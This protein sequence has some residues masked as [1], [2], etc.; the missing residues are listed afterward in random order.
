MVVIVIMGR[1]ANDLSGMKFGSLTAVRRID[2][3]SGRPD[4]LCECKCGN[5][6][7]T[8]GQ[9]LTAG[10]VKSCGC[11]KKGRPPN[12]K[13]GDR[14]EYP[15]RANS[16]RALL[17]CDNPYQNLANAI[18]ALAADDYRMALRSNNKKLME[19][20]E[21]FFQSDWYMLLSNVD[22]G[23]ILSGIRSEYQ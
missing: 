9:Y 23:A 10:K 19:S 14:Q 1:P 12:K 15:D 3:K 17:L 21:D 16:L 13:Y 18:I 6:Y 2:E 7:I 11:M 22:A 8:P 20:V 5:K 4:W